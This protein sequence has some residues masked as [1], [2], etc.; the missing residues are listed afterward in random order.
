MRQPPPYSA[1]R[2]R[3]GLHGPDD[4]PGPLPQPAREQPRAPAA[5]F[6]AAGRSGPDA[7]CGSHDYP[8]KGV[9]ST[10]VVDENG[11]VAG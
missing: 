8:V 1:R 6:L 5:S 3:A 4:G 11:K 9:G 10:K 7:I 2:G